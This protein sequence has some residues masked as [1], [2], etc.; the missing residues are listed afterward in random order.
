MEKVA[1]F[2]QQCHMKCPV[3]ANVSDGRIESIEQT[4]CPKGQYAH[5]I[6]YHPDRVTR[7]LLREY[8]A[9]SGTGV[10]SRL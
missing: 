7:P 8:R 4:T 9:E 2:C 1:T 10:N 6:L 3:V 5:E